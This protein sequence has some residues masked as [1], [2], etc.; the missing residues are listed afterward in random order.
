MSPHFP[1]V[2]AKQVLKVLLRLGFVIDRP[3]GSHYILRRE[4]DRR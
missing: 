4:S 3:T 1:A 2:A